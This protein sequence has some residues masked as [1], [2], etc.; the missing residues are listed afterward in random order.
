VH[1]EARCLQSSSR[2]ATHQP[3][4]TKHA[5]GNAA[6]QVWNVIGCKESTIMQAA[7]IAGLG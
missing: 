5:R 3:F 7:A 1:Q 4:G 2:L 6:A